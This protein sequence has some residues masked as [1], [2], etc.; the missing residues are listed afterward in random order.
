MIK[1]IANIAAL[2]PNF[3]AVTV[4]KSMM[5]TAPAA[6]RFMIRGAIGLIPTRYVKR[7]ERYVYMG[8]SRRNSLSFGLGDSMYIWFVLGFAIFIPSALKFFMTAKVSH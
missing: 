8:K 7:A 6:I 2:L 1:V 3:N 4:L 5:L